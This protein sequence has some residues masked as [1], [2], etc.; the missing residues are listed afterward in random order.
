MY[1]VKTGHLRNTWDMPTTR[2]V[3][4][5]GSQRERTELTCQKL[6]EA[7]EEIFV[8]DGFQAARLEDIAKHAG[9]TRGAFYANFESK[10]DLFI[11]IAERQLRTVIEEI[12]A[13]VL[14]ASGL[15]KKL[16]RLHDVV[17]N[18]G[19]GNRWAILLLE[20]SLFVLRKP[21][22]KNK[23][24]AMRERLYGEIESVFRDLYKAANRKPVIS[25]SV[26]SSGFGGLLQG[27]ALDQKLD[28]KR[29]PLADISKLLNC[30]LNAIIA[31]GEA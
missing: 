9:Y 7:A 26:I 8:R 28:E 21:K 3:K 1:L 16:K 17:L 13:A 19:F 24:L 20:F 27:F 2:I 30:Y 10:E 4:P 22:L 15:D 18:S 23:I 5:K 6:L 12:R 14:S 29:M 31:A 11:T 25:L